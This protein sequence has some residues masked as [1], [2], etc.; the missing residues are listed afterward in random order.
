MGSVKLIKN[1]VMTMHQADNDL[2]SR[3]DPLDHLFQ[4]LRHSKE[5]R[6]DPDFYGRVID[7]IQAAH[8]N[9]IWS[10][11]QTRAVTNLAL[12]LCSVTLL[13]ATALL[14]E[15]SRY[16]NWQVNHSPSADGIASVTGSAD[17][18]R[19]AVLMNLVSYSVHDA[20]R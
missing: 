8:D 16:S 10:F 15:D 11:A 13:L 6:P 18:Q 1:A 3:P 4:S 5:E 17:E 7:R 12:V 20:E 9:S 19:K 14:Y 2:G